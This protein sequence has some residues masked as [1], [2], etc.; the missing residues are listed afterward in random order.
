[1]LI[2][3]TNI[4]IVSVMPLIGVPAVFQTKRSHAPVSLHGT[5]AKPNAMRAHS[6]MAEVRRRKTE[7]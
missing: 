5:D 6:L 1:D 3:L 4:W 2:I 7:G